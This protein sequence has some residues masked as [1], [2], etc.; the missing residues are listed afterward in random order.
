MKPKKKLNE[1]DLKRVL[2]SITNG[3]PIVVITMLK[4]QWDGC[5][6]SAYDTGHTL[7]ELNK[8]ETPRKAYRKNE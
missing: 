7:L 6:Q 5:L 2:Y 3:V 8:N 4:N 1:I